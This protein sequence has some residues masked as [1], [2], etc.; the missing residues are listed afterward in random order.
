M[1]LKLN[2]R[3]SCGKSVLA[4]FDFDVAG[5]FFVVINL[6]TDD[7]INVAFY[8]AATPSGHGLASP[9]RCTFAIWQMIVMGM[10]ALDSTSRV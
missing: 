9:R 2:G 8:C 5:F 7:L 4:G 10:P 3:D 6:N 1:P